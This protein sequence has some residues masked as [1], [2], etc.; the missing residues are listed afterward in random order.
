[1]M[2]HR[3]LRGPF[4]RECGLRLWKKMA[5][6]SA[7]LGWWGIISLF[8]GNPLTLILDGIAWLRLSRLAPPQ[9]P[10]PQPAAP[11]GPPPGYPGYPAPPD[12]APPQ[13][14]WPAPPPG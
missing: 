3:T 14:Q 1:M 7:A 5:G 6:H 4:C 9:G 11:P 12:G 2:Q 10:P 13:Q 8:V